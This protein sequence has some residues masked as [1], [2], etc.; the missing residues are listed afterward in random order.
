MAVRF[1]CEGKMGLFIKTQASLIGLNS[2]VGD[3]GIPEWSQ[4]KG[5]GILV[6]CRLDTLIQTTTGAKVHLPTKETVPGAI[7]NAP[8]IEDLFGQLGTSD[9]T[10]ALQ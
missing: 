10:G 4:L 3:H 9:Q 2:G 7:Q 6:H 5:L 8:S 1:A